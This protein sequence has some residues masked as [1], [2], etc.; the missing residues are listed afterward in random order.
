MRLINCRTLDVEEF[1]DDKIPQYAILSHTWLDDEVTYQD[2]Q[3]QATAKEKR[4][5][6]KIIKA[7]GL[8]IQDGLDYV[9][10]DTC[11]IDKSSSAELS[12][13][14]NSMM[15]WYQQS[16][17]CYTYL[18]DVPA[19]PLGG[20]GRRAVFAQSRWFTRG[21]TLQELL[22]PSHLVFY[23][24]DWSMLT[25]R[26]V[27]ADELSRIT[28]IDASFMTGRSAEH[29]DYTST[30]LLRARLD[31]ASIAQRMS[32]A[33]KRQTTRVEDTAYCLMGIFG[34]NMPLL[35]GEGHKAFL[36]LQ[37]QIMVR[38]D[39]QSL[40]AWHFDGLTTPVGP[41]H[42]RNRPSSGRQTGRAGI[43]ATSPSS[44]AG[45]QDI[46]RVSTGHL[47]PPF[48]M[49]NKG[50]RLEI[51]I[52]TISGNMYG[53]LQCQPHSEPAHVLAL[54]LQVTPEGIY[55]RAKRPLVLLSH[56]T[57]VGETV[58]TIH[59][60][61]Y[62]QMVL[63]SGPKR[64]LE[65]AITVELPEDSDWMCILDTWNSDGLAGASSHDVTTMIR[66]HGL[67][68]EKK[69]AA[70]LFGDIA[71]RVP[72]FVLV[73]AAEFEVPDRL[74]IECCLCEY[75]CS[76][77]DP[78]KNWDL[79]KDTDPET[80][81]Q[82]PQVK[83]SDQFSTS[84]SLT[85]YQSAHLGFGVLSY[86]SGS[87]AGHIHHDDVFGKH[88]FRVSMRFAGVR[89]RTL[90]LSA[91]ALPASVVSSFFES[92][93]RNTVMIGT[94]PLGMFSWMSVYALFCSLKPGELGGGMV[95]RLVWS[96]PKRMKR[97]VV[98]V[99]LFY[100]PCKIVSSSAARPVESLTVEGADDS[101]N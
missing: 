86:S 87:V 7:A 98:Y 2:M 4:G 57:L 36:R 19:G 66:G 48:S 73:A 27:L 54:P 47:T 46:I 15:A 99:F 55:L 90:N 25:T 72:R 92:L 37:E 34:I 77:T 49:T 40:L 74:K 61:P 41:Y 5:Y 23:C 56:T 91:A 63:F 70:I 60:F 78:M 43:L 17:V 101:D 50:V 13:A 80:A 65:Y 16:K 59:A 12:E 69:R 94:H 64:I 26:D 18:S 68:G 58:Q 45:C 88:V 31:S 14:I 75:P 28:G 22:A 96:M 6:A 35:Y 100:V 9:W 20:A 93:V 21:W 30:D 89:E 83:K 76:E 3:H 51:P 29:E 38:F 95:E 67:E 33:S 52:A 82:M 8:A 10:I 42:R 11:C 81:H 62:G 71:N 1:V 32:W 53:V 44:F 79:F 24:S 85:E 97:W 84:T 39:D